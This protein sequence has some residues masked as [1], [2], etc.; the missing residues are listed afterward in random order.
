MWANGSAFISDPRCFPACQLFF[1][2][3]I[4]E[5]NKG[6]I[7]V[8]LSACVGSSAKNKLIPLYAFCYSWRIKAML[9]ECRPCPCVCACSRKWPCVCVYRQTSD[10]GLQRESMLWRLCDAD[11][12]APELHSLTISI[13]ERCRP[14]EY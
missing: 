13:P 1:A 4:C 14:S 10:R 9:L 8:V 7:L 2:G 6:K 5:R 12:G 11:R 3:T